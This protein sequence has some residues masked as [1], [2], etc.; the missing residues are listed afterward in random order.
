MKNS[1]LLLFLAAS[2]FIN[3]CSCK[4]SDGICIDDL[5]NPT[6]SYPVWHPNGQLL[7][8][9]RMPLKR[10]IPSD[11]MCLGVGYSYYQDSTG[12][13]LIN[14]DGTGLRR[15]TTFQLLSPSWSP[16]GKW[17]AFCN[18]GVIYKMAFDGTNF[19]TAHIVVLIANGVNNFFPSWNSTGD[20][21]YY[22]A[23][24]ST[25]FDFIFRM[26]ADGTGKSLVDSGNFI[27]SYYS[28]NQILYT[29]SVNHYGQVFS[30]NSDGSN[31]KQITT[32]TI[33]N[34]LDFQKEYPRYYN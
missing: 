8:F 24:T 1:L 19:D 16:D 7:G 33:T 11:Q 4:K 30:M 26:S 6:C 2:L 9:N 17:I 5:P 27:N 23:Q 15:V 3:G 13:W 25:V 18:G 29:Q 28:N 12:F 32:D 21:I 10:I 20:T 31:K 34:S 14:K 22:L